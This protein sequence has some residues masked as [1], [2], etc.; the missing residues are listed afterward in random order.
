MHVLPVI[1]IRSLLVASVVLASSATAARAHFT[2]DAPNGGEEVEAGSVYTI[3]WHVVHSHT[4]QN[5]GLWYS[6]TDLDGPWIT[7]ASGVPPGSEAP[8]SIHTYDWTVP[9]VVADT[10]WVMVWMNNTGMMTI[11]TPVTHLFQS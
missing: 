7:I 1:R 3:T 9:D 4:I 10:A 8:G 2:L 11:A 6:T 5:W